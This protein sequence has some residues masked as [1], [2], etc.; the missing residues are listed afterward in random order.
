MDL[1]GIHA[2]VGSQVFDVAS[3]E[4][5]IEVIAGFAAPLDIEELDRRGPG[6]GLCGG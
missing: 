3:F 6:R 1:I 4:R 5:A 2:H